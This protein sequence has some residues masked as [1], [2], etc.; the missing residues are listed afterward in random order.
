ML[1]LEAR[2]RLLKARCNGPECTHLAVSKGLCAGHNHQRRKGRTLTVLRPRCPNGTQRPHKRRYVSWMRIFKRNQAT[3]KRRSMTI[4]EK[5]ILDILIQR[6]FDEAIRDM[7]GYRGK[8]I[9][10]HRHRRGATSK[11]GSN[12]SPWY[13]NLIRA[14]ED[15]EPNE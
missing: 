12:D 13:E 6:M 5:N 1:D 11:D 10:G 4:K 3:F 2:D 8:R 14:W 15:N 7:S 9:K